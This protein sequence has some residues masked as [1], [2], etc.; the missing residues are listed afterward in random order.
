MNDR[1]IQKAV[2]HFRKSFKIR[3]ID[4]TTLP[5]AME[6]QGYTVI[7][8][9]RLNN[10]PEVALLLRNLHLE[11]RAVYSRGFT[12]ADSHYRMVFIGEDLNEHEKTLILAHEQGHIYLGH[13]NHPTVIGVDVQEEYEANEFVHYLMH[14][15]LIQRLRQAVKEH[16]VS[17]CICIVLLTAVVVGVI[18]YRELKD[19]ETYFMEY[20]V[21]PHGTKYHVKEC[22][23]IEEKEVRRLTKDDIENGEYEPC[24]FCIP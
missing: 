21:T 12:Y 13:M 15:A 9:R 19:S 3:D 11:D 16:T 4:V 7:E 6:A 14:P 24:S 23:I 22:S 5:H 17:I 2:I 20:Y 1:A 10:E 8:F 18:K